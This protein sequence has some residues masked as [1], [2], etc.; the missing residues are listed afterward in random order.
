MHRPA[1]SVISRVFHL[2][3]AREVTLPDEQ[4]FEPGF[5]AGF[6]S[7]ERFFARLPED[8]HDLRGKSVLDLGSGN[9]STCV[10]AAQQ[11]ARPVVGADVQGF[12]EE[13]Q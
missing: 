10:W 6:S 12:E 13:Q 9:G 11:G 2:L 8:V 1:G 3:C 7:A 5:E 4:Y